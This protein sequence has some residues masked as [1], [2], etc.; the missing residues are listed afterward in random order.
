MRGN[1]YSY[2]RGK[3]R[4][5]VVKGGHRGNMAP[6][7]GRGHH[8]KDRGHMN[9]RGGRGQCYVHGSGLGCGG[10]GGH[11]NGFRPHDLMDGWG[12]GQS[13]GGHMNN[14]RWVVGQG[15]NFGGWKRRSYWGESRNANFSRTKN[16]SH[17]RWKHCM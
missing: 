11:V 16:G 1:Y 7:P 15:Q 2:R 8:I 4:G 10:A 6:P 14:S 12:L 13:A 5:K 3:G 9:N 17:K